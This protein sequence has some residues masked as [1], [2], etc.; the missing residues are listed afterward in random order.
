VEPGRPK[1]GAVRELAVNSP[2]P[3]AQPGACLAYSAPEPGTDLYAP[4]LVLVTRLLAGASKLGG[5]PGRA[6]VYF[7]RLPA[8][9]RRRLRMV[10]RAQVECQIA[11][12]ADWQLGQEVLVHGRQETVDRLK[13]RS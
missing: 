8:I 9:V 1:F 4:F 13:P 2:Q 10:P 12:L 11:F 3:Q 5:G 6:P 7:P